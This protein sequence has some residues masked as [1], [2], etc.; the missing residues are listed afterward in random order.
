MTT[1]EKTDKEKLESITDFG[2]RQLNRQNF[3]RTVVLPKTALKNCGCDLDERN[4]KV[5]IS[6]V[7]HDDEKFIKI[8]PVSSAKDDEEDENDEDDDEDDDDE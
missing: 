3:S 6:L 4:A 2:D 7:Q 5:N 8:S 1:V